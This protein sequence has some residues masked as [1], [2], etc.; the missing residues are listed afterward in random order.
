[1]P[2]IVPMR[3]VRHLC[4][5][6]ACQ[7]TS[8]RRRPL[9]AVIAVPRMCSGIGGGRVFATNQSLPHGARVAYGPSSRAPS[10]HLPQKV[11]TLGYF[12]DW[13]PGG[14]TQRGSLVACSAGLFIAPLT[15]SHIPLTTGRVML[16]HFC[17]ERLVCPTLLP[18][19]KVRVDNNCNIQAD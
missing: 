6:L 2:Q 12:V 15:F 8:Y 5:T 9:Q 14:E 10:F 18:F 17:Q 4:G 11:R 19:L 1:M 13:F 3:I 7:G 16:P